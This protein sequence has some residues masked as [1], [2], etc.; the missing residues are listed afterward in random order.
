MPPQPS[1]SYCIKQAKW[2]SLM[3]SKEFTASQLVSEINTSWSTSQGPF[4]IALN[5]FLF[6]ARTPPPSPSISRQHGC[7][8]KIHSRGKSVLFS[9]V[10]VENLTSP[11]SAQCCLFRFH[12]PATLLSEISFLF[13]LQT[14]PCKYTDRVRYDLPFA[15]RTL[16]GTHYAK[17]RNLQSYVLT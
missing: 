6:G 11:A 15:Y 7:I 5:V 9:R 14:P 13:L 3:K 12:I 2:H 1:V 17:N 16:F 10:I 4:D 8:F